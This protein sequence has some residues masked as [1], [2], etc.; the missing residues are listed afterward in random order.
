MSEALMVVAAAER[1][2]IRAGFAS[3]WTHRS[4]LRQFIGRQISASRRGS[5]LG[6]AWLVLTPLFMMSLYSFV[7]G[8]IFG[9]RYGGHPNETTAEYALGIFLSLAVFQLFADSMSAAP[10]TILSSPTLVKKVVFPLEILPV[11]VVGANFVQFMISMALVFG[12]AVALGSGV[13]PSWLWLPVIIAPMLM[14]AVGVSWLFAAVGVF[15]RDL[16]HITQVLSSVLLF[17]SAVFYSLD[18]LPPVAQQVLSLNPLVHGLVGSRNAILWGNGPEPY[19]LLYL[20]GIAT[21]VLLAGLAVFQ[22]LRQD[23]ADVI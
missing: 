16:T 4:L 17:G 14:L 22:R 1:P 10:N 7:F 12:G 5:Y 23:F 3:L 20:Y 21:V 9:G 13:H 19:G 18:R 11:A 15:L 2:G 8:T 6:L